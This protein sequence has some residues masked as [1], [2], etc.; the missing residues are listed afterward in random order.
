[1]ILARVGKRAR[2]QSTLNV[3]S[4]SL[5][6]AGSLLFANGCGKE[7][8]VGVPAAQALES[9]V[10]VTATANGVLVDSP[11]AEFA[12]APSGYVAGSLVTGGR[13]LSLDDAADD[14]GVQVTVAAKDL[15]PAAF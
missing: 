10:Q 9:Q 4:M 2:L 8:T 12:I 14:S 5:A 13:K 15:P 1:M 7:S 6:I 11:A 3:A